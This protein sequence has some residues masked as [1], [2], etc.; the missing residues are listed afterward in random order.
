MRVRL[1]AAV[2]VVVA[3]FSRPGSAYD[4]EHEVTR[5]DC[6][7]P[8]GT[9]KLRTVRDQSCDKH[10]SCEGSHVVTLTS[11]RKKR[12]LRLES[13]AEPIVTCQGATVTVALPAEKGQVS[14]ALAYSAADDRLALDPGVMRDLEQR[15]ARLPAAVDPNRANLIEL[16][17]LVASFDKRPELSATLLGARE[18][19]A[20]G[21]W[22]RTDGY[23]A[24]AVGSG[25][26]RDATMAARRRD[27]AAQL[28]EQ[29]KQTPGVILGQWRRI[30]RILSE[31]VS[32]PASDASWF[33]IG[34]K[35]CVQQD[36]DSLGMREPF[37]RCYD[38]AAR[39][40]GDRAPLARGPIDD[41]PKVTWH[42][43]ANVCD[44]EK[45]WTIEGMNFGGAGICGYDF[46]SDDLVLVAKGPVALT[47][48]GG[49]RFQL[50]R[51]GAVQGQAQQTPTD[52]PTVK[53]MLAAS[54]G[55]RMLGNGDFIFD[56]ESCTVFWTAD[57]RKAWAPLDRN[58]KGQPWR[59]I[60]PPL[61]APDQGS[62]AI[63]A[64]RG[65]A[66]G[67]DGDVIDLWLIQ[68]ESSS[69]RGH[70]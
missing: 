33:W 34:G 57:H 30:G 11:A 37:M 58:G 4:E 52:R 24:A 7:L 69:A 22:G 40:W 31:P 25:A 42:E 64:R 18:A 44:F 17:G 55:S 46:F 38:A 47:M 20:A 39:R 43:G 62:L 12:L 26:A 66:P 13:G 10:G 70:D 5:G 19:L 9:A 1:A 32:P 2:V 3:G 61:V 56:D 49:N 45:G 14:V 21:D 51:P 35:L 15:W 50:V 54:P 67:K 68:V 23:L 41:A 60:C 48:G 65:A 53:R 36:G 29:R 16:Y 6:V 59:P 8:T 28:A 63:A 27:I